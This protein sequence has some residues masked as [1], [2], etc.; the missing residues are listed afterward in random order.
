MSENLMLSFKKIVN[1]VEKCG[2]EAKKGGLEKD[3][4]FSTL[5]EKIQRS[6]QAHD[7]I[8][9]FLKKQNLS[10]VSL[11]ETVNSIL[12]LLLKEEKE[13]K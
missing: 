4:E 10:V 7:K 3:L 5:E 11:I 8:V 1:D 6:L 13:K 9:N 12:V 2:Y